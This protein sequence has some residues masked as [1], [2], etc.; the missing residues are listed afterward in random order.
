[1]SESRDTRGRSPQKR[2]LVATL[3]NRIS[4][5]ASALTDAEMREL[6][7]ELSVANPAAKP[8]PGADRRFNRE[9]P[10]LVYL[11]QV[12]DRLELPRGCVLRAFC[13]RH[14]K[15]RW[16]LRRTL[17]PSQEA[18]ARAAVERQQGI[19]V[20]PCSAGKT[21]IALSIIARLGLN[22]LILVSSKDLLE[23]WVAAIRELL[24]TEPV[25]CIDGR[26][27]LGSIVVAM[28]QTVATQEPWL[29]E[30]AEHF[31]VVI[32]D[33]CHHGAA[34]GLFGVVHRLAAR[35]RFG[36]TATPNRGDGLT[37]VVEFLLGPVVH[38]ITFDDLVREGVALRPERRVVETSFEFDYYGPEDW[39]PLLA[40]LAADAKRNALVVD[41]VATECTSGVVGL[42]LTGRVALAEQYAA[43]LSGRGLRA[44]AITGKTPRRQRAATLEAARAGEFDVL[45][46]T[47]LADEGLDVPCL[48]RVFLTAPSRSESRLVQRVGR[49][50]RP[51]PSKGAPIVFDFVD[52]LVGPLAYQGRLRERVWRETWGEPPDDSAV[53]FADEALSSGP[54]CMPA[55]ITEAG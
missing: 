42:L 14:G 22:T 55:R 8:R 37:S 19:V 13:A 38:E 47:S 35:F 32:V 39:A 6:K 30:S 26:V 51:H 44:A 48:G 52:V 7:R 50:L 10:E 16:K 21:T 45:V 20:A 2:D 29:A 27:A 25:T 1:V 4:F 31:G 9:P 28:V 17:R 43:E 49:V 34:E 15:H 23:Q 53:S 36:L 54:S 24:G 5:E 41:V 46:A 12:G 40:A 11:E 18:A 3:D 33:E